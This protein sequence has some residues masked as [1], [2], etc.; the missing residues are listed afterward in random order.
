MLEAEDFTC[1]LAAYQLGRV[2][3]S[4]ERTVSRIATANVEI[5][6]RTENLWKSRAQT[7]DED[8]TVVLWLR[9]GSD[10][11]ERQCKRNSQEDCDRK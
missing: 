1:A 6:R 7:V 2:V 8:S 9:T 4:V 11:L 10:T 5:V 3:K